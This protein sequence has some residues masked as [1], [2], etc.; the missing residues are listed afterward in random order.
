MSG[1]DDGS[2]PGI[3]P[4]RQGLRVIVVV[5]GLLA[6][7]FALATRYVAIPWVIV[8]SSMEPALLDGDRVLVDVWTL[9]QRAP[10]P[11]EI[12]LFEGLRPGEAPLVKRVAEPPA[13]LPGTVGGH[14]VAGRR[15]APERSVWVLGDQRQRS[16]DSREFGPVPLERIVGR[17]VLR[18]WP[19]SRAGAV[20]PTSE[21]ID[22]FR[23]PDR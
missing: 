14:S 13:A 22:G 5:L 17:V 21:P 7:G 6:G 11:G 15:E 4:S 16:R 8:G 18:Y 9:R 2:L 19:P 23:L 10:R 20:P 12:V 3:P 1:A